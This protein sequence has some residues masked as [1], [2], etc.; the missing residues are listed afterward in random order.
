MKQLPECSIRPLSVSGVTQIDP[1]TPL[2]PSPKPP[3]ASGKLPN[4]GIAIPRELLK[5]RGSRGVEDAI[6]A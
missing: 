2:L 5:G 3:E 1:P 6:P 4:I